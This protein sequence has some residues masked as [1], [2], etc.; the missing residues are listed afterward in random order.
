M[1]EIAAEDILHGSNREA[2]PQTS[3]T[4]PTRVLAEYVAQ[5]PE[6]VP[7]EA[8]ELARTAVLDTVGVALAAAREPVVSA[9]GAVF[10]EISG[11][12]VTW[13]DGRSA[14]PSRTALRNATAAHALDFDDV[15]DL[16]TGH[17]SAVLVPAVL[18]VAE[19]TEASGALAA[20]GYWR[21]LTVIR[22]LAAGLG[23]GEHYT[24]G[25]HSTATLGVLGASAAAATV[26]GLN[27]QQTAHA[28]GIAVSRAAG[29]RHNFGSMT[30]PLHAGLAASDGVLAA[31][32][33]Q[34][35][36]TAGSDPV[37]G[38][39]G[40]L[41]LYSGAATLTEAQ[42]SAA[43]E[44]IVAT[45]RDPGR[46]ALNLKLFPCC[47]ATNAAADAALELQAS[48]L[49][50]E[51]I[52]TVQVAVPAGG[53]QPLIES[54]P[55]TGLE[56]KFSVHYVVASCLADGHLRLDAFTDAAVDRAP[57]LDLAARITAT[58][59]LPTV[60]TGRL[61]FAAETTVRTR[62]GDTTAIRCD[63]PRGHADRPARMADVLAKFDDCVAFGG[64]NV[65]TDLAERLHGLPERPNVAGIFTDQ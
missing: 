1:P 25:W 50:I 27:A 28:L 56:A 49:R 52:D 58:D 19:Q 60:Q 5:P 41:G 10:G 22:A 44:R 65:P 20:E 8:I 18:A 61:V 42:R 3:E 57:V 11:P 4:T 63:A 24:R 37:G 51:D 55:R 29:S 17:P 59:T 36:L 33:A 30:K 12:C 48:G 54:A 16:F 14:D 21:G 6:R 9:L 7:Q 43:T 40:Y 2:A 31:V 15:D 46:A 39:Y 45:L 38:P 35:G 62:T 53:L 13:L 23:V 47:Y 34:A 32:L 64:A 26:L